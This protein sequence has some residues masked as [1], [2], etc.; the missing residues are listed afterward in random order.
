MN[1]VWGII[2]IGIAFLLVQY[3]R[4]IIGFTGTWG[5]AEKYMGSGRSET[6]C[7]LLGILIFL[8]SISVMF[9]L[10][11]HIVRS[12]FAPFLKQQEAAF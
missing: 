2:G 10:T 12:L 7:T 1:I 11:E 3:R 4:Q 8:V 9:G 6:A 5:W